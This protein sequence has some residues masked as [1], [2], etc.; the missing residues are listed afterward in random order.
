VQVV[1]VVSDHPRALRRSR[2]RS[3]TVIVRRPVVT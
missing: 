3:S 2:S 1:A